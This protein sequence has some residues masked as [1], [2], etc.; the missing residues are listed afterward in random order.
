MAADLCLTGKIQAADAQEKFCRLLPLFE[1]E[2]DCQKDET[3]TNKVVPSQFFFQ[4]KN[5]KAGKDYQRNGLLYRFQLEGAHGLIA[6]SIGRNHQGVFE[7]SN[8]PTD[9]DSLD[10]WHF[11]LSE[12]SIPGVGHENI[13]DK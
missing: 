5:C 9:K 2:K 13:R 12:M 8:S 6:N 4:D 11:L 10:E 3:K 7:K 1:N